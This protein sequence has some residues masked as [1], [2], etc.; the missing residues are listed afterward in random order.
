MF[1][2]GSN[3]KISHISDG[4]SNTFMFAE[5][6]MNM[7]NGTTPSW[8]YRGWV[9]TGLDP[10]YGV[11]TWAYGTTTPV[12]GRVGS[13]GYPG[14][15]HTGGCYFAMGDGS[16]RFVRDNTPAATLRQVA[17]ISEGVIANTD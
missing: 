8:G 14:S 4:T 16:I 5:T 11:N 2:R 7:Y 17:T 9:H 12:V 6:T 15:L 1:G 10:R 3:C 13:W